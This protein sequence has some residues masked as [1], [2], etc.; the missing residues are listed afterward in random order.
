MVAATRHAEDNRGDPGG[1]AELP[2]YDAGDTAKGPWVLSLVGS[3]ATALVL[4]TLGLLVWRRVVV[5][6]PPRPTEAAKPE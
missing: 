4:V 3:G 1:P 6:G 5:T 2:R